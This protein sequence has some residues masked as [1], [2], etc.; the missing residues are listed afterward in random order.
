[1]GKDKKIYDE[2]HGYILLPEDYVKIVDLPIFQRLRRIK[3]LGVAHYV[4]PGAIHNR[5]SHSLGVYSLMSRLAKKL[6]REAYID[7]DDIPVLE[8]AALL[9]DIGHMP[10]SHAVELY[11]SNFARSRG[12]RTF[13]H[14]DLSYAVILNDS[15]L[16]EALN[17]IG[18]DPYEVAHIIKGNHRNPL[19]NQLLSSDLDVDR[20]DYLVRDSLHTGVV[21]G[22]ID[23]DRILE[24]LTVDSELRLSIFSKGLIAVENFY[25]SRLHMYRGVYYHK[26][27]LMYELMVARIWEAL[28]DENSE[29]SKLRSFDGIISLIKSGEFRYIDDYWV[30][31][32]LASMIRDKACSEYL[33]DLAE[34]FLFRKGYKTI[35]DL[36]HLSNKHVSEVEKKFSRYIEQLVEKIERESSI[37]DAYR[38]VIPFAESISIYKE[39]E[40]IYVVD[41]NSKRSIEIYEYPG[42]VIRTLPKYLIIARIYGHPYFRDTLA[43]YIDNELKDLHADL[44]KHLE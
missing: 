44:T 22:A 10:Y 40:A 24:T 34:M 15:D 29:L 1:M 38:F 41:H 42:S 17:D 25:I 13:T 3:Q 5:F 16:K 20:M 9:H 37:K 2:I 8:L 28:L 36:T 27:S 14:E 23:I 39:D 6:S 35:F 4:Y 33:C 30:H 19:Y 7:R 18:I 32:V 31:G 12:E 26:T 21:Y 43:E 11:Y